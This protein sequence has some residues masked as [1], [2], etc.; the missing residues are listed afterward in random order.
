MAAR[1]A[2]L[3]FA[4]AVA[5]LKHDYSSGGFSNETAFNGPVI[6]ARIKF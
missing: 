1:A 2:F 6:E 5:G 4:G 3:P